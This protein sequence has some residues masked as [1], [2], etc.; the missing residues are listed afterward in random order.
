MST[1]IVTRPLLELV[2]E[3]PDVDNR[4]LFDALWGIMA[5][6]RRKLDARFQLSPDPSTKDLQPYQAANGSAKGVLGAWT[7]P[8][9]DWMIHSWIGT[10][11]T[12]FTN[13]HLTVWLG[14]Q[15]KV[16]HFGMALGTTPDVFMYLDYLPRVDLM[17][18]LA[19]LDRYYEPANKRAL[20]L[21]TDPRFAPFAS[22]ELYMRQSQS[23]T[24]LCYL[25]KPSA[26]IIE[27]IRGLAHEMLDRWLGWV[28]AAEPVPTQE[29]A[30]LA[31]RDLLVR[32]TIC[33]R[34]PANVF[35]ERL[36]GK[37]MT[38]RLIGALWG[39]DRKNPRPGIEA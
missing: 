37:E 32:R 8:E 3:R 24:S 20:E 36:F 25:V 9:I 4:E 7:G 15:I 34:D 6:L 16:P 5:D 2:D 11:K 17:T 19:T 33:E 12:S 35:G 39:K 27:K 29:R 10:P 23:A 1:N 21:A 26:E 30:A 14:P 38:T 22:Q 18:D 31:A 13:M 28:D